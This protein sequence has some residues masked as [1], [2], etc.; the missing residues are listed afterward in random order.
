M[1]NKAI[2][3]LARAITPVVLMVGVLSCSSRAAGTG[4]EPPQQDVQFT[5]EGG[6]L[7][8]L[9]GLLAV[10]DGNVKIS[11]GEL[12]LEAD[13]AEYNRETG[14]VTARGNVVLRRG[15]SEWRGTGV[16]GNFE[17]KRFSLGEV[18]G[19]SGVFYGKAAGGTHEPDGRVD[20]SRAQLSTCD[21]IEDPHYSL[22]AKRVVYF[23]DGRVRAYHATVKVGD[24]PVFFWP[25]IS[26]DT[27]AD[28]GQVEV[29]PGY[30]SDWGAYLL[31]GREWRLDERT[32]TKMRLDFRSKRGVAVG[33]ETK[34]VSERSNT[35]LLAYAMRD[36]DPPE[37]GDGYN[38]RFDVEE[39]RYRVRAYHRRV[40][41]DDW[42]LRLRLDAM[43]DIDMLEEWFEREYG[44]NPQPASLVELTKDS[45]R[46]SLSLSARPRVNDYY[47]VVETIPG[48][49]LDLPRQ[50]IASTGIYYQGSTSAA[51]LRMTWRDYDE[52]RTDGLEEP[53]DYE[54]W[55]VDSLHMFYLPLE[56]HSDIEV[57][58]RAGLRLT[59]YDKSSSTELTS[60]DLDALY[61]A[62][63]S[64]DPYSTV[65]VTNYDD[66]GGS[67]SR[68]AAEVGLEL[69]TKFYGVWPDVEGGWLQVDGLRHIVQPYINYT[70]IPTPSEEREHLYFFDATDRLIEQNFVRIGVD[71]RL[72]TKRSKK[73]YTLA[74]MRN[75]ADF[76][77]SREDSDAHRLGDFGTKIEFTPTSGVALWTTALVDM[78]ER[79]VNRREFG[80]SLGDKERCLF[81]FAYQDRKEYVGQEVYSMGS[82]LVDFFGESS[83]L[84]HTYSAGRWVIA[85]LEF[86]LNDTTSGRIQYSYDLLE[87]EL[88]AQIYEITR[89][90]HCWIGSLRLEEVDE[91][92]RILLV[93]YLKAFPDVN[94]DT[95]F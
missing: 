51:L 86:A 73:V 77:L 14:D 48:L 63:D 42:N 59:Y 3:S 21:Q 83:L 1:H 40:V 33:N 37:T 2:R 30:D 66:D 5:A 72:Q 94:F 26:V 87:D 9:E 16:T 78:G 28:S 18:R 11:S 53:A 82:S 93:L 89:D 36:N 57:I 68:Y 74:S 31:L 38:R 8:L 19:V 55:R 54:S 12:G 46:Y 84:A 47:S 43:S 44:Y 81:S 71:Q 62:D 22:S 24:M 70:Y 69:K 95:G 75:Y 80:L 6:G 27:N 60:G 39:D 58:P 35:D 76:H 7:V 25:A 32:R 61:E 49:R 50:P 79:Q 90:M 64:D 67:R 23:P 45:D 92:R 65:E 52:P 4:E 17:T 41:A 10:G 91:D 34:I 20:L 13:H 56:I 29:S 88:A 85:T 15:D